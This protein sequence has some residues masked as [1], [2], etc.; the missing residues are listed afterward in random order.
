M[1]PPE[2]LAIVRRFGKNAPA[3]VFERRRRR[4]G[5]A[6]R[7]MAWGSI[8]RFGP[9]GFNP[10]SGAVSLTRQVPEWLSSCR[11]QGRFA[12]E[13]ARSPPWRA[14]RAGTRIRNWL[15]RRFGNARSPSRFS[16]EIG[17]KADAKQQLEGFCAPERFYAVRGSKSPKGLRAAVSWGS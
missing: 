11:G 1:T 13:S 17:T 16:S 12:T 5:P 10:R 4:V 7:K 6:W 2:I 3:R 8:P 9:Q 15:S 14:M